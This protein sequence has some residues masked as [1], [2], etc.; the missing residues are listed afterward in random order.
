MA[1]TD[2]LTVADAAPVEARQVSMFERLALDPS[3]DVGKLEKLIEMQERIARMNAEAAFNAAM[4]EAQSEMRPVSTDATNPQTRSRYATYAKLDSALRPVYSKH[5]F[6]LSFNTAESPYQDH[7]R[8]LCKVTHRAGHAEL[9]QVDMPAD[10][11]G[12]KGGDVMTK[13]H[14]AGSAF[15]YGMRYL[16]KMIFNVAV[17]E[18]DDD[19]NRASRTESVPAGY[20][21]WLDDLRVVA[22]NGTDALEAAWKASRPDLKKYALKQDAGSWNAIKAAAAKAVRS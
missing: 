11:K 5:G 6:A 8:V 14:A 4:S 9:R 16:L 22:E 10:G 15:S 7:V 20:D 1:G 18:G 13:T 21:D 3:V 2:L 12:A 19:G 17:G